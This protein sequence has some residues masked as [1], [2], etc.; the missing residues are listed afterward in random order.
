MFEV[1]FQYRFEA[2]HRFIKS[3]SIPCMT[4]HGHSWRVFLRI[5]SSQPLNTN[6]MVEEFSLLKGAWKRFIKETVDHSFF[7]HC[8]DPILPALREHIPQFRSLPFPGDPTTEL[9]AAC[10]L[11]KA[12]AIGVASGLSDPNCPLNIAVEIQ[13]TQTNRVTL[14]LANL[15]DLDSL[16]PTLCSHIGWWDDADLEARWIR[17]HLPQRSYPA[18]PSAP[19]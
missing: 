4:P 5:F 2:A 9:I 18:Q 17:P 3:A 7:H 12:Q 14:S 13:E 15:E 16:A 10:F 19:H 8:E 6:E 1:S 11:R